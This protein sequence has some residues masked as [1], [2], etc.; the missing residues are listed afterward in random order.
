MPDAVRALAFAA[1]FGLAAQLLFFRHG[2][3]LN[4]LLAAALFL[5]L[6]WAQRVPG[7]AID[8]RDLWIPAGAALFAAFCAVRAEVALLAF[9]VLATLALSV[10]S[11]AVLS[12]VR[13]IHLPVIRLIAEGLDALG[14]IL[15]R[16]WS[17][18]GSAL[19]I[20]GSLVGARAARA[21]AY[22]AG[23]LLA[24]PFLFV[25]GGLFGSA[26]AVFARTM[27]DTF[28]LRRWL[29]ALGDLPGRLIIAAIAA[30][31]A[32][33]AFVRLRTPPRPVTSG[34]ARGWLAVEPA[35]V[36]LAC[37]DL[38]FALFVALQV[39]YL[40]GGRDTVE[41]AG[42]T[43][44]AYAR[45]GFFE[46]IAVA[47]VVGVALFGT[48]LAMKR[49]GRAYVAAALSLV[50]LSGVVLV[51]AAYRLDLYQ[52]AYG[53]TEQ[54]LY[55]VAMIVFLAAAL[56]ILAW[57]IARGSMRWAV[58]PIALAALTVAAFVNVM[59]PAEYVVR[60]N[61]ARLVDPASL[62]AD[63]VRRL[64]VAYLVSLGD[65][66]I[67]VLVGVLPSLPEPDRIALGTKLRLDREWRRRPE[68]P[69]QSW[70]LDRE[71]ARRALADSRDELDR[72]PSYRPVPPPRIREIPSPTPLRERR[73]LVDARPEEHARDPGRNRKVRRVLRQL[74][75]AA[76]CRAVQLVEAHR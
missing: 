21:G 56:A 44:S 28:D 11:V 72:Y 30:W 27:A 10:A 59:A 68:Q 58:Q 53:W 65:G 49:R 69:W 34:P 55:A 2:P 13:V 31:L 45:R 73:S 46:L 74:S 66:A 41:A 6:A 14:A 75:S 9:D 50:A 47:V 52:R 29:D 16:G 71:R 24:A 64:D 35:T 4:V 26:D 54:R 32:A 42:L 1:L 40:F 48:E 76:H 25:F 67:P 37:I 18:V 23:L 7:R 63:A 3:G 43:H 12:G 60:A 22:A 17:A 33:G 8:R 36:A 38:M 15:V 62:P 20:V 70:N 51:S 61:V 57:S 19:P 39:A 5:G